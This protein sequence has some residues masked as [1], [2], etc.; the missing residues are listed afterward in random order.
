MAALCA[1]FRVVRALRCGAGDPRDHAV[2][3]M[4]L[5]R[6]QRFQILLLMML[7]GSI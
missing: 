5:S 3:P 7:L 1:Q 6:W 4:T 2:S